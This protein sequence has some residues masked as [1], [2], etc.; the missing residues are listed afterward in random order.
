MVGRYCV[1][2]RLDPDAHATALYDALVRDGDERSW[3]Y[4]PYGPFASEPEFRRWIDGCVGDDPLFFAITQ[5]GEIGPSGVA[6]Y[7]RISPEAGSIEVGHIHFS[8]RLKRTAAATEAMYL[9]MMNA[10]ALGYRRYE[11]KCDALNVP[12]R[13]AAER[14]GFR[15]EGT[16]RNATVYKGR[17]RDTA[18]FAVVDDEW[19]RL[20]KEFER[21][22]TPEN[23]DGEGRQRS[24][25]ALSP[26]GRP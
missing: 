3:T 6:S 17:S 19:P 7:L 26:R 10:F 14:L 8:A 22:L 2:D 24:R 5:A 18:W 9:L 23:F 4:L 11:W 25:L 20:R 16:F 21:W 1:L 15:Y 12:S 13:S